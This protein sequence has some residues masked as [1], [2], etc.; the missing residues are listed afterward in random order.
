MRVDCVPARGDEG[1]VGDPL[2]PVGLEYPIGD[3][4]DF[5]LVHPGPGR[6][7]A[8]ISPSSGDPRRLADGCDLPRCLDHA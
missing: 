6:A 3:R 4:L 5:V 2:R 1:E 7:H 8:S